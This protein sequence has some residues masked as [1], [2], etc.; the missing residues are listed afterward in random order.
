MTPAR[1][2]ACR[3]AIGWTIRGTAA[4]IGVHETRLRRWE[5]G[6]LP[7][8]EAYVRWI[9]RLAQVHQASPVPKELTQ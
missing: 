4:R 6:K 7:A 9:E 2:K 1:L 8:P 3:E 5:A